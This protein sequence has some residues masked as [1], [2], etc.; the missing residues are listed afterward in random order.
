MSKYDDYMS[1]IA[2]DYN[3][4]CTPDFTIN[5]EADGENCRNCFDQSCPYYATYNE[6]E[7]EE[8]TVID[9]RKLFVNGCDDYDPCDA[10]KEAYYA[11]KQAPY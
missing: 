4:E 3:T 7:I 11:E 6:V 10:Y 9:A 1:R 2:E 5:G 8:N